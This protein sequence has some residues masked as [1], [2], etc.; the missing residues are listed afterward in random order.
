MSS[1]PILPAMRSNPCP[2]AKPARRYG[3][4]G[5]DLRTDQSRHHQLTGH[6]GREAGC[7]CAG[8]GCWQIRTTAWR[9]PPPLPWARSAARRPSESLQKAVHRVGRAGARRYCGRLVALAPIACWQPGVESKALGIF[10]ALYEAEKS[11]TYRTAAYRGMILS[12]GKRALHLMTTA[13]LGTDEASQGAALQLVREV[14]APNA[15][16]DLCLMLHRVSSPVQ[17]ALLEGLTQRGDVSAASIIV[18]MD[19]SPALEVRLAVINALGILGDDTMVP[20][21]GVAATSANSDE[22]KAARL[23]LVQ[24][25]RGNPTETL[26]RL[27]PNAKPE[28]QAE[29]A[30]RARRPQR[31]D[32]RSPIGGTGAAKERLGPEGRASSARRA[33]GRPTTGTD[34]AIRHRG[35]NRTRPCRCRR[36]PQLRLPRDSDPARPGKRRTPVASIGE[37]AARAVLLCSPF[38]AGSTTPRCARPSALRSPPRNHRST[39]PQCARYATPVTLNSCR[40]C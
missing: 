12:S 2:R 21:L 37:N 27:L 38:A 11:D 22:Q 32:R 16:D 1:S 15:T 10:Q 18:V 36:G 40:M 14:N 17:V 6:A 30:L 19:R 29:F 34:G 39:P 35:Q 8:E 7:A 13:I 4:A 26:L 20:L 25:R 28:V 9:R 23:A 3:G 33:G 5:Q 24:L 31:Q